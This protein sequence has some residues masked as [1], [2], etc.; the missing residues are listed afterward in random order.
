MVKKAKVGVLFSIPLSFPF[1]AQHHNNL[2]NFMVKWENRIC[3][4]RLLCE[5]NT[6][7]YEV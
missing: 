4:K 2:H 7:P 3:A 6:F 5:S 1:S